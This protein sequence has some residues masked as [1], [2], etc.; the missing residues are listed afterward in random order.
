MMNFGWIDS[1]AWKKYEVKTA[2]WNLYTDEEDGV[3]NLWLKIK[4]GDSIT[5]SEDTRFYSGVAHWELNLVEK[6]LEDGALDSG[7]RAEI[8]VGYD[9]SRGGW[10]TNFYFV[11]HEGSDKNVID[12]I[13]RAGDKLLIRVSGE[14][15]D[16]NHAMDT[17]PR[18]KLLIE[19]WFEKD[20]DG[21]RTM[22]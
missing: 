9:E 11:S 18:S 22:N 4:L 7:F 19:T 15:I 2:N 1:T 17:V 21:E 8:P 3:R 14:I 12:V 20:A 13:E 6:Q 10:I 5:Q 16:V